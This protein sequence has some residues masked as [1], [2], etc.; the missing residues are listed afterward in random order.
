[1]CVCFFFAI[2][3][4]ADAVLPS[5]RSVAHKGKV[6][7]TAPASFVA[8]NA[9]V[10]G[11]VKVSLRANQ[12]EEAFSAIVTLTRVVYPQHGGGVLLYE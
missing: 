12:H 10:V 5:T 3:L 4:L 1:M 9:T 7:S 8:P 2:L 6:P 11:D